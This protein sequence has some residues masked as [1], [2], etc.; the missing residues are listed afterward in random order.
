MVCFVISCLDLENRPC[1]Y[2][3][4]PKNQPPTLSEKGDLHKVF[5]LL[6]LVLAVAIFAKEDEKA[7]AKDVRQAVN[8]RRTSAVG[9]LINE[10][11]MMIC[12]DVSPPF[13]QQRICYSVALWH[14][15][16]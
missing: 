1:Y 5:V 4:S 16:L 2:Q 7:P 9:M 6:H 11:I 13:F 3:K 12:N 8:S 15:V 10:P 14:M